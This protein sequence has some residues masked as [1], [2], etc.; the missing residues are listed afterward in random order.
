F[1][2]GAAPF[3]RC[4]TCKD[5]GHVAIGP[6]EPQFFARL[7]EGLGIAPDRFEQNNRDHWPEMERVFAQIF[8]SQPRAHWE[9]VF[10][11]SDACVAPVLS[12]REAMMH[13]ANTARGVFTDHEGVMQA[14]PAP[15]FSGTPGAIRK[16]ET[17]SAADL[18][19][20]WQ[21]G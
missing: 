18:L 15:R 14:V 5:G 6:L 9:A 19:A 11:G 10:D 20:K 7:L 3:Y 4:Y 2:D 16:N 17:L 12:M 8:A 1:L 21:T 13:P